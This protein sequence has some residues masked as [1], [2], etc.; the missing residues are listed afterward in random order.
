MES[1]TIFYGFS[2]NYPL[3][4]YALSELTVSNDKIRQVV[5]SAELMEKLFYRKNNNLVKVCLQVPSIH[6]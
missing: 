2:Q 5:T 6:K 3:W 1:E 4:T